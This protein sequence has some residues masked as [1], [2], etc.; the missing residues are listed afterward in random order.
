MP[1]IPQNLH[2]CAIGMLNAGMTMNVL[3][4]LFDTLGKVFKQQRVRKIDHVGPVDVCASRRVAK[5]AIFRTPTCAIASKL[6]QLL[7]LTPMIHIYNRISA[8]TV[9]NRL[10]EGGL[11]ARHPYVGCVL[12]RRVN[13]TRTHWST[14]A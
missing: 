4:V 6:P 2:E 11:S 7:V 12:A 8:Q 14:L 10:H 1:R 9:R 3:L 13:W 5:I